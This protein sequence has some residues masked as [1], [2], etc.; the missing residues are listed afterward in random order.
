[1]RSFKQA[2]KILPENPE[3]H[4]NLGIIYERLDEPELAV[5]EY[6][7]YLNLGGRRVKEVKGWIKSIEQPSVP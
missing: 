7:K 2:E 1:M 6:R 3:V 4:L 5:E